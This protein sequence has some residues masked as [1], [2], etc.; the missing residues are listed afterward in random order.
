MKG[1]L[2]IEITSTPSEEVERNF[3]NMLDALAE[4][5]ADQFIAQARTEVA[6]KLGMA[7]DKLH[8]QPDRVNLEDAM[9]MRK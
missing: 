7:E 4:A 5:L 8:R 3:S 2:P 1:R 6:A 9:A